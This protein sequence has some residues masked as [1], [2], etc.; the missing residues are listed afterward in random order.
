M[1]KKSDQKFKFEGS[2]KPWNTDFK[3]Y[4]K[5][6]SAYDTVVHSKIMSLLRY[7]DIEGNIWI[8]N[9]R[10]GSNVTL[11]VV[12]RRV[13]KQEGKWNKWVIHIGDRIWVKG[14]K[15]TVR[16][17]HWTLWAELTELWSELGT[18]G[19]LVFSFYVLVPSKS[20][21]CIFMW[22]IPHLP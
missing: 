2:S 12:T 8:C 16:L 18:Q 9:V 6:Q 19:F 3:E 20:M 14:W 13:V 5:F 1:L 4:S 7:K 10:V 22:F 17:N 15:P 21:H 11:D